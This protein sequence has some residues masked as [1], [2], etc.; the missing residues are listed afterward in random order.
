MK[1]YTILDTENWERKSTFDFF[2]TFDIPFYNITANVDV[3]NLKAYCKKWDYSF[4]ITSL[5][6]SQKVVNQLDNFK[7]RLAPNEVRKY[8]TSQAGSTVLLGNNT[9]AFCY[10]GLETQLDAYLANGEK[11]I[12]Y[13]K[14]LIMAF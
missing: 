10:F 4:F 9:F 12:K 3:T 11:A 5:F 6:I 1:N 13:L 14:L 2:Q 8:E 7:L